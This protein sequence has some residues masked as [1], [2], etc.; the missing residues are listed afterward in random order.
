[1]R[2]RRIRIYSASWRVSERASMD[3]HHI[4]SGMQDAYHD[5]Y[6]TAFTVRKA[7]EPSAWWMQTGHLVTRVL[8]AAA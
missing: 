3:S 5:H 8:T 6:A 2:G 7:S 1:M 4:A